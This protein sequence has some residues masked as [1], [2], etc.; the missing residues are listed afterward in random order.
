MHCVLSFFTQCKGR[1]CTLAK[2][3]DMACWVMTFVFSGQTISSVHLAVTRPEALSGIFSAVGWLSTVGRLCCKAVVSKCLCSSLV[4]SVMSVE[5]WYHNYFNALQNSQASLAWS[6]GRPLRESEGCPQGLRGDRG[7]NI[8]WPWKTDGMI[9]SMCCSKYKTS[10]PSHNG[11]LWPQIPTDVV[12][13][14]CGLLLIGSDLINCITV[15]VMY[16]IFGHD[17]DL[18]D[19]TFIDKDFDRKQGS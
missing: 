12:W 14:C 2:V 8:V 7:D 6:E 3:E 13:V 11:M 10:T 18:Y 16:S 19:D 15:C 5:R 4:W 17:T 1:T 9:F